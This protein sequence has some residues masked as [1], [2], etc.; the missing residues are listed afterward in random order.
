MNVEDNT[1]TLIEVEDTEDI[2]LAYALTIHKS[3]G[4][5]YN[6][7]GIVINEY[8]SF[9]SK[10]LL[11]TAITRAKHKVILWTTREI[12]RQIV[13]TDNAP[14]CSWISLQTA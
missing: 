7:C 5:E 9:I 6:V 4:S 11:Y 1:Y 2:D 3:Q 12:L 13:E 14:R 8:S 10:E